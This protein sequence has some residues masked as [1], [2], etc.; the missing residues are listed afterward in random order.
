MMNVH[1]QGSQ[2]IIV[3]AVTLER[4]EIQLNGDPTCRY[5]HEKLNVPCQMLQLLLQS[6][7]NDTEITRCWRNLHL[8]TG[9][10]QRSLTAPPLLAAAHGEAFTGATHDE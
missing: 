4:I 5:S 7:F 1:A 6:D 10:T 3:D 2:G 8:H 9:Q